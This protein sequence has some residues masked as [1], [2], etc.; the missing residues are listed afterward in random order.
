MSAKSLCG[1]GFNSTMTS[2]AVSARYLPGRRYHGTPFQRHELMKS[3]RVQKVS[4]SERHVWLLP[5]AGVLTT[6]QVIWLK[7]ARGLKD[8]G[9]ADLHGFKVSTRGWFAPPDAHATQ[10]QTPQPE[11]Q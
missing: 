11:V 6:H 8:L 4:T 1:G 9:L 3:R 10:P 7:W 5:I 2:V